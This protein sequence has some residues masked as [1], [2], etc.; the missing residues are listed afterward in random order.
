M[1]YGNDMG[2]Y[3]QQLCTCIQSQANKIQQLE[4]MIQKMSDDLQALKNMP[5]TNIE[6]I[7]YKFDQLKVETLEGTLNIGLNPTD[8][9]PI[10]NFEVI[11]KGQ[12]VGKLE[13]EVNGETYAIALDQL[14]TYLT[15]E[16]IH[17]LE[18]QEQ[19]HSRKLNEEQRK[20]VID[21]IRKQ[22]DTRVQYYLK[23]ANFQEGDPE[24][25]A[26]Q[27]TERVKEEIAQ[28]VDHFIK[29]L[30]VEMKGDQP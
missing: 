15:E 27:I 30:P 23:T 1:Y 4:A 24:A 5:S 29:Y 14:N 18:I 10:E 19:R 9:E 17:M 3:L 25:Q 7:E 13:R 20:M 8:P 6:K 12:Q 22:I 26:D 2:S 21:D 16:C 11:Q 28:S